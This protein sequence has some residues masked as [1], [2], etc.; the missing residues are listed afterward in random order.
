VLL[1]AGIGVVG[2][3]SKAIAD[4]I[5]TMTPLTYSGVLQN[6][7]G[8]PV[9]TQQSMQLTLWDDASA[10][11][12]M[13]QKCVTP[14]QSVTPDAQGRFQI[15]LDQACLEA[16]RANPNLWVQVQVGSIV[17]PR[18]K[19][20]AVP[21]AVEAGRSTRTVLSF[22]GKRTTVL[23]QYCGATA[24]VTGAFSASGGAVTGYRAAKVLCEQTCSSPT[25]HMCATIE[26]TTSHTIGMTMPEGWLNGSYEASDANGPPFRWIDCVGYQQALAQWVAPAWAPTELRIA[27][28]QCSTSR[29][30]LCCD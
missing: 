7:A 9:T 8:A 17:L 12:S 30:I 6:S 16:V 13:N 29:P 19:L 4:G 11:A 23:G 1:M 2:A 10:N 14:T 5:P 28:A 27:G 26:A 3:V 18:S 21:Y 24:A 20:G 25:A 15:V 22:M